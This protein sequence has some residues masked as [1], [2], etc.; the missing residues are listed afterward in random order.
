M[1]GLIWEES[2]AD[3]SGGGVSADAAMLRQHSLA[4]AADGQFTARFLL[5]ANIV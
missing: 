3:S 1:L 2:C 4:A 5:Q